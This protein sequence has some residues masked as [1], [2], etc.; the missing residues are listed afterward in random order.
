MTK[1]DGITTPQHAKT[2]SSFQKK[3]NNLTRRVTELELILKKRKVQM[4]GFGLF[5]NILEKKYPKVFEDVV[6]EY[7]KSKK[8]KL[9]NDKNR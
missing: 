7:K 6:K 1:E 3:V 2:I 9:E 4:K 5:G 8:E